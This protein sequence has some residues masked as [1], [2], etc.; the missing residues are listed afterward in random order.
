M[1]FVGL[2]LILQVALAVHVLKT[3]RPIYWIFLIM[4]LPAVGSIAYCIV[5]LLP[6]LSGNWRARSA[7]RSVRKTLDPEAELRLRERQHRL[8]GSVDA[9]RR[10]AGELCDAGRYDEAV[11]HYQESLTGLYE[12]DPDLMLGLAR[13]QFGSGDFESSRK[14]LDDLTLHNP[15]FKSSDGHLLYARVNEEL[16]DLEKAEQEYQAVAAYFAG[17]E[18]KARYA[19]LLERLNKSDEAR[20]IYRDV[21]EAAELA[22]KHYRKA[23]KAW[24]SQAK[25]G[26]KRLTD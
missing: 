18:A 12:R 19:A 7:I 15:D 13:A 20:A 14:T 21:V 1:L 5:E 11:L 17:A 22:P 16:G 6:E 4:F 24:I 23:Q 9:A 3:G 10:L 8:S 2:T 26:L 25:E